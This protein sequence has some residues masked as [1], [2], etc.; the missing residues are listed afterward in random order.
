L[1]S[2]AAGLS[3]E[4]SVTAAEEGIRDLGLGIRVEDSIRDRDKGSG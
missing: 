2:G 4:K 1:S 3:C